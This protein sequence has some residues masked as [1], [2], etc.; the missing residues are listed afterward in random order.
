MFEV[1]IHDQIMLRYHRH[2]N[3]YKLGI[4]TICGEIKSTKS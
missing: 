2:K 4:N 1:E 3:L